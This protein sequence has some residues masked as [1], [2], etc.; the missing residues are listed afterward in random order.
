MEQNELRV[1]ILPNLFLK[2][3]GTFDTEQAMLLS[4]KIAGVCYNKEGFSALENENE[5]KTKKRI[6]ITLN[7][8]HHSVYDHINVNL[9]LQNIPKILAMVLNNEGQYTT[10]EKSARYTPVVRNDGSII[11]REEEVL[12]N[13]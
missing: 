1:D 6:N 12:Y 13:K 11:T 9:N 5:D 10:S 7:G 3:D 8:G 2:D 4:G